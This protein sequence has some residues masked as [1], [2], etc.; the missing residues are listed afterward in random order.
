[1]FRY[2]WKAQQ[3]GTTWYH[4]HWALQAWEGVFGGIKING[5][6]SANYDEDTGRRSMGPARR[7]AQLT[8][9]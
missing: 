5:P 8:I 2:T 3:Y 4:S 1:M 9:I 7:K 6:A